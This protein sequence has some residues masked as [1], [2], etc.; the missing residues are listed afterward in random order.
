MI[1]NGIESFAK[2][3]GIATV[4]VEWL[5]LLLYY[6]QMPAYF[7]GQYPISYF[8]TLPQTRPVFN[9]CYTLAGLFFWIFIRHHLHKFY[10]APVKIFGI[11]M[12]LF[13]GL[14]L[15]PYNLD[16][17]I[18]KLI[19]ST[20]GWSS[21]L[22]FTVGMYLLARNANNKSVNRATI[23]AIIVSLVLIVA[24]ANVPKDSHLIF[25]L[26]AGSWLVWQVWVLWISYYSYRHNFSK[27]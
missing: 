23:F 3:A 22:F 14:A 16:N 26:E 21:S 25:A 27:K 7:S 24:F 20:L 5:A 19:H 17:Q 2:Y 11:S 8:A 9:I 1:K 12:I 18:S 6:I 15:T 13:V 4:G 10:P